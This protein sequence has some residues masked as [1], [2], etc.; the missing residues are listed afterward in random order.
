MSE[1]TL[2]AESVD[3]E[4]SKYERIIKLTDDERTVEDYVFLSEYKKKLKGLNSQIRKQI[5]DLKSNLKII[6]IDID[7]DFAEGKLSILRIKGQSIISNIGDRDTKKP[8]SLSQMKEVFDTL[9]ERD[10]NNKNNGQFQL[11]DIVEI[12]R[13]K[14]FDVS[15]RKTKLFLIGKYR[16][17]TEAYITKI[18]GDGPGS[19]Y[20]IIEVEP[21]E[22]KTKKDKSKHNK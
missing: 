11:K 4:K 19:I 9:K 3:Q 18:S 14:Q 10:K 2:A 15:I 17:N 5:D 7:E 1:E 21:P 8:L 12:I 22:E 20:K 16:Q 13:E 6:N